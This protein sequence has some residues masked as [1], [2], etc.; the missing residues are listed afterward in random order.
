VGGG[1]PQAG[2]GGQQGK[3]RDRLRS[4][5]DAPLPYQ[6]RN[7]AATTCSNGYKDGGWGRGTGEGGRGQGGRVGHHNRFSFLALVS[8]SP[9]ARAG[10][11]HLRR[12]HCCYGRTVANGHARTTTVCGERGRWRRDGEGRGRAAGVP[13]KKNTRVWRNVE[14]GGRHHVKGRKNKGCRTN[15]NTTTATSNH[16][17]APPPLPCQPASTQFQ[18]IWGQE[19]AVTVAPAS[20]ASPTTTTG[21][22]QK[23][24]SVQP[25]TIPPKMKIPAPCPFLRASPIHF[26]F[27]PFLFAQRRITTTFAPCLTGA[28]LRQVSAAWVT[29]PQSPVLGPPVMTLPQRRG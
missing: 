8:R 15:K 24:H 27:F 11:W 7:T 4:P 10:M 5:A 26:S 3:P 1:H 18:N 6:A 2:Q 25:P 22:W 28:R 19:T 17:G 14:V 20:P 29:V 9:H 21:P 23:H 13:S 12:T 16:G